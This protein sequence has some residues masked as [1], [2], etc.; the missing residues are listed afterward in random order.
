MFYKIRG[1]NAWEMIA[2]DIRN[3]VH[4]R[5]VVVMDV[6]AFDTLRRVAA[7]QQLTPEETASILFEQAAQ[8]QDKDYWAMRCWDHLSPRQRQITAYICRGDTTRDIAMQLNISQTTV[9]SH[10]AVILNKFDVN[11]RIT[12]RDLLAPWDLSDYL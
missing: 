11:S 12:L 6:D 3:W 4:R 8:D 5:R 9:K 7:R 10:V 2:R 1:M